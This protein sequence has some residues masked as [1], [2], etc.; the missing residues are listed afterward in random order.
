LT[1]VLTQESQDIELVIGQSSHNAR[2]SFVRRANQP[3]IYAVEAD[4]LGAAEI[5]RGIQTNAISPEHWVALELF[6][7]HP[8]AVQAVKLERWDQKEWVSVTEY[9]APFDDE[10][11]GWIS[12]FLRF[13]A[14]AP[15]DPQLQAE[16]FKPAFRWTLVPQAGEPVYLIE[17]M[18]E[19]GGFSLF[20]QQIPSQRYWSVSLA[21]LQKARDSFSPVQ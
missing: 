20:V 11:E 2:A 14:T 21:A 5:W 1:V 16:A 6:D 4:L 7:L 17:S 3:G 10:L 15:A 13:E 19:E 8:E 9:Q 12:A 18:P